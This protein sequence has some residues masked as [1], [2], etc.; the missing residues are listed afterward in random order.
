M[1]T[2]SLAAQLH[3]ILLLLLATLLFP[4][5]S[6]GQQTKIQPS[7]VRFPTQTSA[8]TNFGVNL[9]TQTLVS[10]VAATGPL[11][12]SFG[13]L[14][15]L[16]GISC[17]GSATNAVTA[18]LSWTAPGGNV[19]TF[20]ASTLSITDNGALDSGTAQY[21]LTTIVAKSG[22]AVTYTTSSTLNSTACSPVPQYK[23]YARAL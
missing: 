23:V 16:A 18:T 15:T 19:K 2:R 14:Q 3:L 8:A 17:T 6:C 20:P 7:D 12:V 13:A 10:S 1:I 9:S 11:T 22:T 21:T 5:I 4:F